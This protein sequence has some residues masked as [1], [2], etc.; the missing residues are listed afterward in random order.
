M[1]RIHPAPVIYHH[2]ICHYIDIHSFQSNPPPTFECDSKKTNEYDTLIPS[3]SIL[4]LGPTTLNFSSNSNPIPYYD[5]QDFIF[6]T[7]KHTEGHR[8]TRR[9]RI[10]YKFF[11]RKKKFV[12]FVILNPDDYDDY[13]DDARCEEV[14][15]CDVCISGG[16]SWY[17]VCVCVCIFM[18]DICDVN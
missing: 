18:V 8:R 15:N 2:R 9:Y 11:F 17:P 10:F 13:D 3:H 6:D 5:D 7:Q 14:R 4:P 16:C 12:F 1:R